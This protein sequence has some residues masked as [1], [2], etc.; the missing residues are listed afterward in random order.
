[1]IPEVS[2]PLGDSPDAR[3]QLSNEYRGWAEKLMHNMIEEIGGV[4]PHRDDLLAFADSCMNDEFVAELQGLAKTSGIR[5]IE[6]L[7]ANLYYDFIKLILGCTAF[8]VN[9]VDGPIHAR[10][11]DWISHNNSLSKY[12]TILNYKNGSN[13]RFQA[14][15][16]PGSVGVL[17]GMAPGRFAIT[18]NA[19]LSDEPMQAATSVAFLIREVC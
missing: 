14:V 7:T 4:E 8:A 19:V 18:L 3:W 2:I 9:S 13:T 11:M 5:F 12:T 17:S 16:W 10:N 15:A 6:V 1:M